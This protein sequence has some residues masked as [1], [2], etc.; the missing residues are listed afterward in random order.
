[1]DVALAHRPVRHVDE[2]VGEGLITIFLAPAAILLILAAIVGIR[3]EGAARV[4]AYC[5]LLWP[6]LMEVACFAAFNFY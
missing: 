4:I 2:G 6:V 3:R 5:A 1:M